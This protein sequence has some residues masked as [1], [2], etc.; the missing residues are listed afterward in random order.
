MGLAATQGK[1][2]G[3][4]ALNRPKK[5]RVSVDAETGESG[6]INH[7][8]RDF[9]IRCCQSASVALVPSKLRGVVFPFANDPDSSSTFA[10]A[11]DFHL[12]PRYRTPRPLDALLVKTKA[13]LDDFITEKYADDIAAILAAWSASLE[14]SPQDVQA[15]AKVLALTFRRNAVAAVGIATGASGPPD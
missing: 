10:P 1:V 3:D 8:R 2:A 4:I 11:G 15:I 14:Q 9:L 12:H 5:M 7:G 13:G 6:A